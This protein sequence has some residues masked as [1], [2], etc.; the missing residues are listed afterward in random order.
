MKQA[1]V[2]TR[3]SSHQGI[4]E[5]L[6][7]G[8][9]LFGRQ[10]VGARARSEVFRLAAMM[11]S[12][13]AAAVHESEGDP[14]DQLLRA[15][16]V[17]IGAVKSRF[18]RGWEAFGAPIANSL[19]RVASA[20]AD[21]GGVKVGARRSLVELLGDVYPPFNNRWKLFR[22]EVPLQAYGG[23]PKA[24][25]KDLAKF[26]GGL[27][28]GGAVKGHEFGGV[29]TRD[30]IIRIAERNQPELVLPLTKPD[31][32]WS[33]I[34]QTGIDKFVTDRIAGI[35]GRDKIDLSAAVDTAKKS[36]LTSSGSD[37]GAGGT[38]QHIT[39]APVTN[40]HTNVVDP[41][42]AAAYLK[43]ENERLFKKLV[44]L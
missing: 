1:V 29:V 32:M 2:A 38:V 44:S 6:D 28:T 18:S 23:P 35:D 21:G 16:G 37:S 4:D 40:L 26:F 43:A 11:A 31:R 22:P 27:G 10:G 17:V 24:S 34:V 19:T 12:G 7:A 14:A 9:F 5:S 15:A 3:L 30:Q 25:P 36:S 33:L 8:H 20:V 39:F 41:S 42:S 13:L